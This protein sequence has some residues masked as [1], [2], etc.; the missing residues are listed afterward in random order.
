VLRS[1]KEM[2]AYSIL[3]T[4]GEIGHVA[5]QLIDDESLKLRCLVID[6]GGWPSGRLAELTTASARRRLATAAAAD[7]HLA[8]HPSDRRE[9]AGDDRDHEPSGIAH[10]T[11]PSFIPKS[12]RDAR[13]NRTAVASHLPDIEDAKRVEDGDPSADAGNPGERAGLA[14]RARRPSP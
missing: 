6:A 14:P 13:A 2:L 3:T 9:H 11:F 7:P 1:T 12:N 10:H 4:D 8:A 5:D